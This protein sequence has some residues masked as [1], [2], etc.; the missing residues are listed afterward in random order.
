LEVEA[1]YK[2]IGDIGKKAIYKEG[3]SLYAILLLSLGTWVMLIENIWIENG[4]VNGAL[5]TIHDII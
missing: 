5:G 2:P 4:L 3:G 1:S